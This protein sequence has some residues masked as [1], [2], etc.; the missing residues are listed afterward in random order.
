[1]IAGRQ[2]SAMALFPFILSREKSQDMSP[3]LLCHETIHF[4]Q[5]LELLLIGFYLLYLV[6]YFYYRIKGYDRF[7]AYMS[8]PFER[9]A[10]HFQD[11]IEYLNQRPFFHWIKFLK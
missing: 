10:Y 3:S 11:D 4:R 9:E 8:I 1:L 2:T 5:Q 6:F 7:N